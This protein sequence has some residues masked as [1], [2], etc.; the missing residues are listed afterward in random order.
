V[1]ERD[2]QPLRMRKEVVAE[3][4]FDAPDALMMMR[5]IS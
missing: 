3:V 5:R 2:W 4:V 1:K